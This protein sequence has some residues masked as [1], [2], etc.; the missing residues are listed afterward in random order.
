MK[1]KIFFMFLSACLISTCFSFAFADNPNAKETE[2]KNLGDVD[3]TLIKNYDVVDTNEL[4]EG[5]PASYVSSETKAVME[6]SGEEGASCQDISNYTVY[7]TVLIPVDD[8]TY[9]IATLDGDVIATG[10][11]EPANISRAAWT[12]NWTIPSGLLAAGT[13]RIS[14]Y[15]GLVISFSINYS[16]KGKTAVGIAAH[17][18]EAFYPVFTEE[19]SFFSTITLKEN[20]GLISFGVANLSDN[21]ITYSGECSI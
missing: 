20:L 3:C 7:E 6:F 5:G 2:R 1:K 9:Q 10:S 17:D 12:F 15:K 16:R 11:T 21:T 18:K 4:I 19:N 8:N 13:D 14:S